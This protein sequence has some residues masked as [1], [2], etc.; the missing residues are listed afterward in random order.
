MSG[1]T[2]SKV[3]PHS[4]EE[5]RFAASTLTSSHVLLPRQAQGLA[6]ALVLA[7]HQVRVSSVQQKA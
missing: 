3:M 5:L 1:S 4:A 2:T 6:L 7:Q